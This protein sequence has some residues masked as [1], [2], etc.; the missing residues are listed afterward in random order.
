MDDILKGSL[1]KLREKLLES[2]QAVLPIVAIVLVLCFSIAPV[3]PSILLCFLLGAAMI[4]VGIMFFTLG[5]EMSMSPMGERV[6][7]VLTKS[8]SVPLIIGAGFVL[9]FLITISEPDLQVL[10]NQVPSIPNMT[11]ILS[12]AA[13]VGFFLVVAFLRMLLS[14]A[15][16]KL[17]VVFYALIFVLA[18]FVPKEFLAVAFDSGGVTTGPITVPFIMALG[19]GVA[20]IRSDRHA[21][22]DSFGL[23]ALCSVGPIL[24]VLLLGI[25]FQ[26]SDST[27]IPPVLPDVGDSVELWQLFHVSLPTYLKEIATSLLPIVLMFG[28]FQ[29]IALKL[30]RRSLGRIGVGLLYTY[31]G[32]VLFLTGANV[33]FMPA[34]NYLGQVLAGRSFR[35]VLVPIGMLIGYFIVKAE[36]AVYVLNKQVEEITDGAISA[37][38]MGAALSAGVSLSVGLAMV[39]VLTGISILW[40]L[41]PGYTFAIGISFVV[42]KLYTAIAFDAGGVASGPMTAT[43]LLPLAQGACV[44]AGGNIVTDAFGVVAM[45]AMTPLITV[46]LMGLMAQF[47]QRR[48]RNAQPVPAAALAFAD[49]PDDAIIEL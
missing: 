45:V 34:G 40:F 27:Y 6:G 22:D 49:L 5:A 15:L 26:A 11:L 17:L 42:P 1:P 21:A 43:F 32:L 25:L 29:L 7:A 9:G 14:V 35:W 3:S 10:A 39:R 28:V 37:G 23:V 19:V 16:P 41:I 12:V 36:P 44:A 4:I 24:A 8:R 18:A 47:K 46:Q 20:A 48:A 31:I 38:T 30:D 2:L 33:G 13:G